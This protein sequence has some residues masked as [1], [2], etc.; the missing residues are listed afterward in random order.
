MG[1]MLIAVLI[2]MAGCAQGTPVTPTAQ[3]AVVGVAATP[4]TQSPAVGPAKPAATATASPVPAT[5]EPSGATAQAEVSSSPEAVASGATSAT[6]ASPE[7]LTYEGMPTGFTPEGYAYLGDLDAPVIMEEYTDYLCGF[8][9][10]HAAQTM[11]ALLEEYVATGQVAY[12]FHDMPLAQLHPTAAQG[13]AAALCVAQQGLPLFWAMHDELFGRQSEWNRLPDPS[14]FLTTLAEEIGADKATYE[15][16]VDTGDALERVQESVAAAQALGMSAT[17]NFRFT[18]SEDGETYAL[19]GAQPLAVFRQWLDALL[20]GEEPPEEQ[21]QEAGQQELPLWATPKG[22]APDPE[23][24]GYNLAGDAYKGNLDAELVVIE[25]TDFQCPPCRQHAL[26][27]QPALDKAM[28]D[29]GEVLWVHKN[30]PLQMH[31]QSEAAAIAAE[32]AGDAGK[33]WEMH[34]LLFEKQETWSVDEPDPMLIVLAEELGLDMVQFS[35]CL[36]DPDTRKRVQA[37]LADAQGLVNASPSFVILFGDQGGL[38]RGSRP[39]DE[40]ET[41]LRQLQARAQAEEMPAGATPSAQP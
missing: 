35:A 2:L 7:P 11:P 14:E 20:A 37:D 5:S 19:V 41:L 29:S 10:R 8:C 27:V 24:P 16:C 13:H 25:F 32:C 17:P 28:V 34:D 39:A 9:A 30:L 33:F 26:E 15:A 21:R 1:I 38:L 22:L 31:P 23:R 18:R 6:Q 3:E 12:V 40:F 36:E 4:T